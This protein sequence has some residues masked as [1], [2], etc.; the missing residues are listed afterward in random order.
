MDKFA[1][2]GGDGVPVL[3][4]FT[5]SM[6]LIPLRLCFGLVHILAIATAAANNEEL[7][8]ERRHLDTIN[9]V[10]MTL[11]IV[12]LGDLMVIANVEKS[13]VVLVTTSEVAAIHLIVH[14]KPDLPHK[15]WEGD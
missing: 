14:F 15:S 5:E 3:C 13:R 10:Y 12:K 4:H 2:E 1:L 6:D 8:C 7:R 9:S 11:S